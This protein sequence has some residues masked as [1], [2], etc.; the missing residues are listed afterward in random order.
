MA[1]IFLRASN[2]VLP[3]FLTSATSSNEVWK[4]YPAPK[5]HGAQQTSHLDISISYIYKLVKTDGKIIKEGMKK[6]WHSI[7]ECQK[8]QISL[9]RHHF[10][11]QIY[12]KW[13]FCHNH[14]PSAPDEPTDPSINRWL[15][16]CG[17]SQISIF[18]VSL[19]RA[20]TSNIL[21]KGQRDNEQ[22]FDIRFTKDEVSMNPK[23]RTASK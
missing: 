22:Q 4:M 16:I 6:W 21:H 9:P 18:S 10:Q 23:Q 1:V 19:A 5:S 3:K 20:D 12:G 14:H 11:K 13:Y 7:C 17:T 15:E 8:K 2:E